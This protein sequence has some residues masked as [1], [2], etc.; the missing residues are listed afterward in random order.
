MKILCLKGYKWLLPRNQLVR[1]DIF[2][3]RRYEA[4]AK[5]IKPFL[6]KNSKVKGCQFSDYEIN[7][8]LNQ[9][10]LIQ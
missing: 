1:N 7:I 2:G 4:L 3:Y 8:E 5:H 6:K 9:F 10:L